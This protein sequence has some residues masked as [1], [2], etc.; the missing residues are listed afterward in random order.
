LEHAENGRIEQF[1]EKVGLLAE[2]KSIATGDT[3]RWTQDFDKTKKAKYPEYYRT[4]NGCVEIG[5]HEKDNDEVL[6]SPVLKLG[7][8]S[9]DSWQGKSSFATT[10]YYNVVEFTQHN[11]RTAVKIRE[12]HANAKG[13]IITT[14]S[15]YVKGVGEVKREMHIN[16]KPLMICLYEVD[17]DDKP[18]PSQKDEPK[19]DTEKV[20]GVG[21]TL[22]L[23]VGANVDRAERVMLDW[24]NTF[25]HTLLDTYSLERDIRATAKEVGLKG[26]AVLD[27]I[28]Q[29]KKYALNMKNSGTYTVTAAKNIIG[30]LIRAAANK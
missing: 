15:L 18:G 13:D 26:D 9:G 2:G 20:K 21:R 23:V 19:N 17:A 10:S 1:G 7:A 14:I 12:H 22:A 30:L 5:T 27:A 28:E 16:D 4:S 3:P 11:N 6:W 29:G 8:T 24:H 25:G